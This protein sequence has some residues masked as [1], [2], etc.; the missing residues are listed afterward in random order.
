[1]SAVSNLA[2]LDR[3]GGRGHRHRGVLLGMRRKVHLGVRLLGLDVWIQQ[4]EH[5]TPR[6]PSSHL[7][8]GNDTIANNYMI[9]SLTSCHW[10]CTDPPTDV[11]LERLA[12]D[13]QSQATNT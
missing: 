13:K 10:F 8:S 9:A 3:G 12:V 4:F 6:E 11:L 7:L 2:P 1:M 5:R